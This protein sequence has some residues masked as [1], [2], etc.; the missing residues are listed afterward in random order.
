MIFRNLVALSATNNVCRHVSTCPRK[1]VE[2]QQNFAAPQT[3]SLLRRTPALAL[4]TVAAAGRTALF[5][6]DGKQNGTCDNKNKNNDQNYINWS[7]TSPPVHASMIRRKAKLTIHARM[8]CQM[9]SAPA[10]FQPSSRLTD[11]IAATQGV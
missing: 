3:P 2:V 8:H 4:R 10:H 1:D 11:A 6:A 7:H 9:T 5:A